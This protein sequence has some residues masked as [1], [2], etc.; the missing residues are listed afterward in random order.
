MR[1]FCI[2]TKIEI[3]INPKK[4]RVTQTKLLFSSINT[5]SEKYK[6]LTDEH[7]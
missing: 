6:S 3:K 4:G 2:Q 7:V 5:I 1:Q